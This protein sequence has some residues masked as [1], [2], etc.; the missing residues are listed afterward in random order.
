MGIITNRLFLP[1]QV[2]KEKKMQSSSGNGSGSGYC[3]PL[4]QS[5]LGDIDTWPSLILRSLFVD[6]YN[7]TSVSTIT[8]FFYGN[9]VPLHAAY[10]FYTLCNDHDRLLSIIHFTLMYSC[11]KDPNHGG[12]VCKCVYYDMR[13]KG[14][15]TLHSQA[16]PPAG[17]IPLGID[18]TGHGQHIR[19]R[20]ALMYT[21]ST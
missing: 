9:R 7:C 4:L 6:G 10:N 11:W 12:G 15:R 17:N 1:L 21:H 2:P 8:A 19:D 13:H 5:I 20:L 3:L 16:V 18:A 14:L